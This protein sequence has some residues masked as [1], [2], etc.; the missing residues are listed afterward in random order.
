MGNAPPKDNH[1]PPKEYGLF[2]QVVRG[3][4]MKDHKKALKNA[5]TILKKF[6][7]HGETLAMKGLVIGSMDLKLFESQVY[8]TSKLNPKNVATTSTSSQKKNN[9]GSSSSSS[10]SSSNNNGGVIPKDMKEIQ[11]E[12][13]E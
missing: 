5:D 7:K 9:S 13:A 4:E 1:L 8:T 11:R 2:R 6:P 12:E 10:S 3:Y